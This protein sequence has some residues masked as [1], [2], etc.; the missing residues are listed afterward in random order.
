MSK[1]YHDNYSASVFDD[2]SSQ[3]RWPANQRNCDTV[4]ESQDHAQ[5]SVS[6]TTD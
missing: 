5:I 4:T 6:G 1:G 2:S 3:I